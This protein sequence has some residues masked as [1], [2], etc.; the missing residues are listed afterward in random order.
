MLSLLARIRSLLHALRRGDALNDDMEAEFRLHMDL[1][2]EELV[3]AGLTPAEAA[4]R[5]RLEFG[6]APS[7]TDRGRDAR[8]LRAFD[9][10]RFSVL[11]LKLGGRMLVKHPALTV[12]ATIA[13][14]F[15]IAVGTVGFEIARQAL[16]PGIID[17]GRET[18]LSILGA[19]DAGVMLTN[20]AMA[21]YGAIAAMIVALAYTA[22]AAMLVLVL[23]ESYVV[24]GGGVLFLGFSAFRGTAAFA[25]NLIAYTF[26]VGIKIFML[27]LIVGLGSQIARGWIPLIQSSTF[28]GPASPLFQ[29][30]GGAVIFAVLAIRVPNAVASRLSGGS[31]LHCQRASRDELTRSSS[32]DLLTPELSRA[33]FENSDH[34]VSGNSGHDDVP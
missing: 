14:A 32:R 4:R 3:R 18:S 27:Y 34:L 30:V 9:S 17:I 25:E 12:I 20:P 22:I 29:V 10:L 31:S 33:G 13:V 28:F 21:I 16:W 19:L 8:G 15:A 2:A 5:A 23:V 11:D 7:F 1:R 24:L 6:S 26:G